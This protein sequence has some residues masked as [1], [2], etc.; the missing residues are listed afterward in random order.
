MTAE[1]W[2]NM[3]IP[4]IVLL[5][6][7]FLALAL[8]WNLNVPAYEN[9][10]EIEHAEVVRHIAATGQLPA[11]GEAEARGYHVRQEAS[12]PPLYHVLGA[13]WVRLL[14]LPLDPPL[15][16]P[17]PGRVVACGI[18]DTFYGKATWA[19]DPYAGPP[20]E[21]HRRTVHA[22]RLLSTLLQATTVV[23][24]WALGRRLFPKG[25]LPLMAAAFVTFN[26][27][28]LLVAAGVNNDNLVTPLA[29]WA[30]VLLLI[31]W[32][33]GP[34]TARLAGFG[35]LVG[36]AG[37]SKLSGL[38]LLGIGGLLLVARARRHRTPLSSLILQGLT[39]TV[40]AAFLVAPWVVRNLRLYGDPTALTPM[41]ELVGHR[42]SAVEWTGTA[43]LMLRSYWGQ[44]PCTFYPRFVYW[45]FWLALGGGLLGLVTG[46]TRLSR[47]E[48]EGLAWLAGWFALI[49]VAWIR[50][51]ALTP[52]TGGRLLF[53]AA[54]SLAVVV[55]AGWRG[56]GKGLLSRLWTVGLPIWAA[57][58]LLV[59]VAP[60][61]TPPPEGAPP[62]EVTLEEPITFDKSLV[63]R[64]ARAA[65]T[66]SP[67]RCLL[68]APSYCRPL[69]DVTLYWEAK[70][71]PQ[72]DWVMA[73]QLVSARSGD[74]TLRLS[75]N[76]WPGGGNLPTSR[77]PT[78][79]KLRARYL[80]PLPESDAVTQAWDLQ[81]LFFDLETRERL[82]VSVG[83]GDGD[84]VARLATLR[85][86]GE[87]PDCTPGY[88]LD[89]PVRFG[90]VASLTHAE[91]RGEEGERRVTLCWEALA[92]LPRDYTVF[93]HAYAEDGTLIATGDAPPMGGAFPTSLWDAGDRVRGTHGITSPSGEE[94][95]TIAVGLYDPATGT[96]LPALRAGERLPND[97]FVVW[98]RSE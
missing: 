56:W 87:E 84:D 69:L 47:E 16:E 44:L 37:L 2:R 26:P 52:A 77:W 38:G 64:G 15:A 12:Q 92:S 42:E 17:V 81:L 66:R 59:G 65:I 79:R 1:A 33:E 86:P 72:E 82:P 24:T 30:M 9:L 14:G 62:P 19:R 22:L 54:P 80:I 48:R 94:T 35:A 58:T 57:L 43:I 32:Q 83:E 50:W 98:R 89:D 76:R 71:A 3:R 34:T 21:G 73:L 18:T 23:G 13:L 78:H 51:N 7:A 31:L 95:S 20:W 5:L 61:F 67:W 10:D 27:Q 96:R 55:A 36:L 4:K 40:P 85:V 63:L 74:D 68:M 97:A 11:H 90:E 91:V 46:W 70:Q 53:P 75:Y 49:V 39:M 93:V 60:L 25:P 41:L 28:F 8:A 45:P 6:L 29:T 88:R